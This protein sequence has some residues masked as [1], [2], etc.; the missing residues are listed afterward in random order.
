MQIKWTDC[1][2]LQISFIIYSKKYISVIRN[3]G[4]LFEQLQN[5]FNKNGNEL[6]HKIIEKVSIDMTKSKSEF[7]IVH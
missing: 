6:Q 2:W 4:I 5:I 7:E 3:F 1:K